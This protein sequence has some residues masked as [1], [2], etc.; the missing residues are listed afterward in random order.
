MFF[1]NGEIWAILNFAGKFAW[2]NDK[3]AIPAMIRENTPLTDF[4]NDVGTKSSGDDLPDIDYNSVKLTM[5][6]SSKK[7]TST[8]RTNVLRMTRNIYNLVI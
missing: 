4:C 8:N 6:V 1:N 5:H 7:L 3:F 2:P